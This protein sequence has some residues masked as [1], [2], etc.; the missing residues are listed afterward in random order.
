MT[1]PSDT[2][3]DVGQRELLRVT[4]GSRRG[5]AELHI[6]FWYENRETGRL[7]PGRRGITIPAMFVPELMQALDKVFRQMHHDRAFTLDGGTFELHTEGLPPKF[8]PYR[9]PPEF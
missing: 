1:F 3:L 2:T 6:R 5:R 9:Y 4:L 8:D 7:Q